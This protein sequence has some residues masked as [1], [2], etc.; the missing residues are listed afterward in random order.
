[1]STLKRPPI[2]LPQLNLMPG[3]NSNSNRKSIEL[4]Q[5][6]KRSQEDVEFKA[7]VVTKRETLGLGLDRSTEHVS[8]I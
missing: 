6:K 4:N 7:M 8:A 5:S 1:M 3:V 2:D